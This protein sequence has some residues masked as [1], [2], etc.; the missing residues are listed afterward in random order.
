MDKELRT[1]IMETTIEVFNERGLKFTMDDIAK[2][3]SISKKTIYTIFND[4][5]ELCNS[6]V[7]YCFEQIKEAETAIILN[8][9][10]SVLEK[11]KKIIIVFPDRY[12]SVDWRLMVNTKDKFP[13]VYDNIL[14]HIESGW[15][16]TFELLQLA[17]DENL[18][19]PISPVVFKT[20]VEATIESFI[21][22]D[23]LLQNEISYEQ[24]LKEMVEII[25]NGIER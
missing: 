9:D 24:A 10:L 13:V 18:V 3:M 4:K 20:M 23:I 17:I 22:K 12:A 11:L 16:E 21:N 15:D 7:D 19:R 2:H 14:K 5:V 1:R 6:T 8:P 25:F